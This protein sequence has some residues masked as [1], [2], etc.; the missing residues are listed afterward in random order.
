M[1][2][3]FLLAVPAAWLLVSCSLALSAPGIAG[4]GPRFTLPSGEKYFRVDVEDVRL[5]ISLAEFQGSIA[6]RLRQLGP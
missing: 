3:R 6:I 2:I 4:D 5:R 1:G